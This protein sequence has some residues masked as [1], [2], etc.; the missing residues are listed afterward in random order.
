MLVQEIHASQI[1]RSWERTV[2]CLFIV[3]SKFLLLASVREDIR[4][5]G[6]DSKSQKGDSYAMFLSSSS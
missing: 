1:V 3:L 6:P 2:N 5:D 4:L